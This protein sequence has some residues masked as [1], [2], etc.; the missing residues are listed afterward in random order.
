MR[1]L[2]LGAS[3]M[4]GHA[5]VQTLSRRGGLEVFGASR[6]PLR[7]DGVSD[8]RLIPGVDAL[9]DA[10]L[11]RLVEK[12]RPDVVLNAVGLIKQLEAA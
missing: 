6:R 10:A 1:V 11:E 8:D 12:V 3:G 7:L 5:A 2:V 9:D 4:L